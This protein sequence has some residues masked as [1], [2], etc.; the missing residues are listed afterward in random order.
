MRIL[1]LGVRSETTRVHYTFWRR[2]S[3]ASRGTRTATDIAG[4]WLSQHRVA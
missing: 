3:V 2:D 1:G 4:R